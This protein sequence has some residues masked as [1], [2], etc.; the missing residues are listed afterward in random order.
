VHLQKRDRAD[1]IG[2]RRLEAFSRLPALSESV[3]ETP[4]HFKTHFRVLIPSS[5]VNSSFVNSSS[6]TFVSFPFNNDSAAAQ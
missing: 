5:F 6:D 2:H 4:F 1:A 3:V